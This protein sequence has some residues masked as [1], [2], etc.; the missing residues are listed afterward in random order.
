MS[1]NRTLNNHLLFAAAV[2]LLVPVA[3]VAIGRI[4]RKKND[5]KNDGKEDECV[6]N[7]CS[8]TAEDSEGCENEC[9]V[10][11]DVQAANDNPETSIER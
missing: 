10:K 3:V 2:G 4:R 9:V 11:T 7:G 5:K 1:N 8:E 6:R